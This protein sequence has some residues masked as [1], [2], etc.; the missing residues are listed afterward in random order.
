[1]KG[2]GNDRVARLVRLVSMAIHEAET[3]AGG[4]HGQRQQS[5]AE[6]SEIVIFQ[7]SQKNTVHYA[8][9]LRK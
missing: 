5:G 9:S 8:V 1:M 2:G 4:S 3:S 6:F 7:W